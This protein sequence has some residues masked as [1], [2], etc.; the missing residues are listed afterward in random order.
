[1]WVN[2]IEMQTSS[3][4]SAGAVDRDTYIKSVADGIQARLPEVFDEFNIRKMFDTP[5]PTQIVLLQE[6]ERYDILLL[7]LHDSLFNLQRALKG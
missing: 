6:L 7:K 5:K 4:S 3:S 2:L 1:M